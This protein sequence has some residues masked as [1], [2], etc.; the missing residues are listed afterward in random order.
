MELEV[1][2]SNVTE[3]RT[4]DFIGITLSILCAIH[5]VITPFLIISVPALGELFESKIFH[6]T[7]ILLVV[8]SFYQSV[9]KHYKLHGSKL[10]LGL[11]FIGFVLILVNYVSELFAHSHGDEHGHHEVA[12]H[13][14]E[15]IMIAVAI[16]G[17]IFLVTSHILNIRN[18]RCLVG[19]GIC[20]KK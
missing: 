5:C 14:D 7:L 2:S 1:N 13:G 6:A 3:S 4:F 19:E 9:Y 20:T 12:A 8:F 17:G 16:A 10:T 18:C 11:G 15:T